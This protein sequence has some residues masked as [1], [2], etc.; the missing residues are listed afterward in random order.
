MFCSRR[1]LDSGEY[2]IPPS[3]R[4]LTRPGSSGDGSGFAPIRQEADAELP[5]AALVPRG[6]RGG[7]PHRGVPCYDAGVY[8]PAISPRKARI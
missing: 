2:A 5:R 4:P 3:D 6:L 7:R 8:L 1:P